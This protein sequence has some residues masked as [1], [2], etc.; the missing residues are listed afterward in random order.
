MK[1]LTHYTQ[2][3]TTKLFESTGAFF[4]FSNKQLREQ[5]KENETY[6]NLGNGLICPTSNVKELLEGFKNISKEGI[7]EDIKENGIKGI[8]HRELGNY[9][10][11]ITGDLSDTIEALSSYGVTESQVTEEYGEYYQKCIDNDCF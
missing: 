1:Y 10:T 6:V 4:A 5:E 9:E 2:A 8:I 7:A 11:Q 3:A